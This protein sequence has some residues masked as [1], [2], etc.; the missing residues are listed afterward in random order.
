[1]TALENNVP[2]YVPD[3]TSINPTNNPSI[4][5]VVAERI[6]ISRRGLLLG[7]AATTALTFVGSPIVAHDAAAQA[8]APATAPASLKRPTQLG[9]HSVA[10]S[11]AD[12][13]SHWPDGGTAR[14]RSATVVVTKNDGGV[15]GV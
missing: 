7:T 9:F 1:M 4:G 13:G 15:V 2:A 11:L 12:T 8:A 6:E 5:D 3:D 10:K 14:P